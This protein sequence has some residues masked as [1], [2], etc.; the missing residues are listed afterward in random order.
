M[1][2]KRNGL[3]PV[4]ENFS[5]LGGPVKALREASLQARRGFT[6]FDWSCLGASKQARG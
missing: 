6:R 2:Q 3:L 1:E 5:D 4:G